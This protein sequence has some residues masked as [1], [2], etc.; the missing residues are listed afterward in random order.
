MLALLLSSL[1]N[2]LERIAYSIAYGIVVAIE[3]KNVF[4]NNRKAE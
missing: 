2:N 1:T 4:F 3:G